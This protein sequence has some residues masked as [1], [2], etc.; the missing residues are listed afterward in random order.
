MSKVFDF[1]FHVCVWYI[2]M[3]VLCTCVHQQVWRLLVN[4]VV[5]LV[6]H[7]DQNSGPH[8]YTTSVLPSAL[9]PDSFVSVTMFVWD[10]YQKEF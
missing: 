9:S 5:W 3:W 7:S 1:R 6:S 4:G 10:S 8:A 2:F